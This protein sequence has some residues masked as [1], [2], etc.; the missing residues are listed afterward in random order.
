MSKKVKKFINKKKSPLIGCRKSALTFLLFGVV[1]SYFQRLQVSSWNARIRGLWFFILV[2]EGTPPSCDERNISCP[3]GIKNISTFHKHFFHWTAGGGG[4]M[5]RYGIIY[6]GL[7]II[8]TQI[9]SW[10]NVSDKPRIRAFQDQA[11]NLSKYE[12]TTP[13]NKKVRADFRWTNQGRFFLMMNFFT[14]FSTPKIRQRC[15]QCYSV[16]AG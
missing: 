7:S 1:Y 6:F 15:I 5:D 16:R 4:G 3:I 9:T 8:T 13:K 2:H 10:C 14:I 12:H 11:C